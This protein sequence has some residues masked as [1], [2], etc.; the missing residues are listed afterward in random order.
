[1]I[2]GLASRP[3]PYR[4]N[5]YPPQGVN[6][7]GFRNVS[8]RT[9]QSSIIVAPSTTKTVIIAGQSNHATAPGTTTYTTVSSQAQNLNIYDGGIYAGADPILGATNA[10]TVGVS[11]VSMRLMDRLISQGKAT[12]AIAVPIAVGGS[13]YAD[14]VPGSTYGLFTRLSTAILRCRARGLE[15][16]AILWA[17]GETDGTLGTS[18][19]SITAS[20]NAITDAVRAMSCVA[21]AYFG[22]F[23]MVSGTANSAVRTG[24]DNAI[25]TTGRKIYAGYDADTTLTVASGYR[26]AD[27]THLSDTGLSALANGWQ[28]LAFP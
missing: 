26:L 12:R 11:S 21:P 24:I 25:D 6:G 22:K 17:M 2:I 3:D 15:P 7:I 8:S 18:A 14:W 9:L 5:E 23:T 28:Q 27:Q 19:A 20:I 4:V 1:L 13:T 16:D 10:A